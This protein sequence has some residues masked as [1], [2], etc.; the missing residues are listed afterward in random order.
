M[1]A[2]GLSQSGLFCLYDVDPNG[3]SIFQLRPDQGGIGILV[4][5]FLLTK[6]RNLLSVRVFLSLCDPQDMLLEISTLRY[7][8]QVSRITQ[9]SPYAV[10]C[11]LEP[12]G[13]R[14]VDLQ[15]PIRLSH[16]QSFQV[17]LEY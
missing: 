2:I 1:L 13:H 9:C 6:P 14:G 3:Y 10:F 12:P 8:A 15:V 17:L 5:M 16:C 4:F 11:F 7:L